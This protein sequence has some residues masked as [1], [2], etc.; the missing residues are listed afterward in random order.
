MTLRLDLL[1]GVRIATDAQGAGI[2]LPNRKARALLAYLAVPPGRR[3]SR[4]KLAA[5]LW[6][7]HPESQARA[8]LRQELY[9]LRRALAAV[10][11]AALRLVE[12]AVYLDPGSVE[13]DVVCLERLLDEGTAEAVEAGVALYQGD[14][15]EGLAVD[16]AGFEEWLL[17]ERERL[18][19]RVAQALMHLFAQQ[20]SAG[21]LEAALQTGLRLLALEPAQESVHR[22]V[23]RL[24]LRLGRRGAARHQYQLCLDALQRELGV[25]PELETKKLYEEILHTPVAA[26]GAFSGSL[27]EA[28]P[29]SGREL[30]RSPFAGRRS[31]L[32][33][34][35]RELDAVRAG[36][37]RVAFVVGEPGIGKTRLLEEFA[38]RGRAAGAEVL[39]GRCFEGEFAP[40]FAPFAEALS[41]YARE[42]D[43]EGL[44]VELGEFAGIVAKIVPEL[45]QRL[46]N[47][48]AP[49]ALAPEE[50]RPRLLD[51]VAQLLWAC[52][53]RAPLVLVLDDL[54]WADG[55]TL[56][57]LR[58]LARFVGRH[59]VLLLAAHR[60]SDGDPRHPLGDTLAALR[61]EVEVVRIELSG[62]DRDS[63]AELVGTLA[64]RE[65]PAGFVQ[66]ITV[67]TGGNPFF[68][69]EVLIHL[70]EEGKLGN[71]AGTSRWPLSIQ[72]MGIPD[73]V[74][75]V[76]GRRLLRL[77]EEA[78]RLLATASCCAGAFRFDIVAAA[79]DLEEGAALDALDEGLEA[80]LLRAVGEPEAY[81]FPHALIRH[82][83]YS[84]QSPSRQVR[85]HRRLA[86]EMERLH[87]E[88]A[89]EHALEIARQ[90]HHSAALPGAGRGLGHCMLA[91]QRAEEAADEETAAAALR[92]ALDLL[93]PGD[94]RRPRLVARLG[95]A[96]AWGG[97]PAEAVDVASEAG[98]LVA[99][100]EGRDAAADYLAD[101]AQALYGSSF[102]AE[103]WALAEQ[104]LRYVG[105]RRDVTWARLAALDLERREANDPEF[106]GI[107]LDLPAR[108]EISRVLVSNL[109]V[110]IERGLASGMSAMVY[111]SREDALERGGALPAVRLTWGGE[112]A[113]ASALASAR[114]KAAAE[115]GR[116]AL[117]VL[118]WTVVARSQSALGNLDASR[119]AFAMARDLAERVGSP[120][121]L[122]LALET[123]AL[124]HVIVLGAGY[125]ALA[126][127]GDRL[128]AE[129]LPANRWAGAAIRAA[130][131][132]VYAHAGRGE[133]ARRAIESLL[134]A[135]ERAAGWA[136]NYSAILYWSIEA[137]WVL[138]RRDH[139]E[140]LERNL[141]KK[142]LAPDFRYPHTDARLALARLCALTDRF[143]E[144]RGWFDAARR[145]L[146]EQ[147]AR[148]LRAV[149]DLDEAWMELRR[150]AAGDRAR[151][152]SL[153]DAACGA[154]QAI[155][156]PGWLHLADGLRAQLG[157]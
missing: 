108:R 126:P 87:G 143:D 151:A 74:R 26:A 79:A 98:A 140:V 113:R 47:L 77:S 37:G 15:L 148:P 12:D 33:R 9:G 71:A 118:D 10:E 52:A 60:D 153:L 111:D 136:V 84:E 58:Y 119:A 99:A 31:E 76:L 51:A 129:D 94:A 1:G 88:R 141:R 107:P 100:S 38:A 147:E 48:A 101:A 149:C 157:R 117:A 40:P 106:P 154:F 54:H 42:R 130:A 50:E 105:D 20:R 25:E 73:G 36:C 104:G 137:L 64:D 96:L 66:A 28:S 120:P 5:L 72:E 132:L 128:L 67:E 103:A 4:D 123:L 95:L 145:V 8:S 92:M 59:R 124:E 75:Q 78:Y 90:W 65:V 115:R 91:A 114:A 34:L 16:A 135:I 144:A 97:A 62:L 57:L 81:D 7:D 69:R 32:A 85:L 45:C 131:A 110:L 11:P 80:Q 2:F 122:A 29:P 18:R 19:E 39:Y 55:A 6:G 63:V 139:V 112:Y 142:T 35:E 56:A 93:P 134:P 22:G 21:A 68:L 155:G 23:I 3:H 27:A 82:T 109:P 53:R 17:A 14:L 138:E 150:A 30:A 86:E 46:P 152:R 24:H 13:V 116:L 125:E 49:V 44:R 70:L 121:Y 41:S 133:D 89:A 146:E 61:R 102:D 83:L 127:V 43:G 156:M